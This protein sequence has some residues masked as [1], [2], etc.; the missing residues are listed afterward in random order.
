MTHLVHAVGPSVGP[1]MSHVKQKGPKR[2]LREAP[3]C[4]LQEEVGSHQMWFLKAAAHSKG[5]WGR[6]R[7]CVHSVRGPRREVSGGTFQGLTKASLH[8]PP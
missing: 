6:G 3:A 7:P 1:S 2:F 4:G 5:V 8:S